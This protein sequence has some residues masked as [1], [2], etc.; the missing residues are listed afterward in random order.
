MADQTAA[1]T[2]VREKIRRVGK[3]F[4]IPGEM[5]SLK[6]IKNGLINRTY[7]ADYADPEEEEPVPYL[8][9]CVNTYVFKDPEE[10]MKNIEKV[11]EHLE[12]ANTGQKVLRF[13]YSGEGE[14]RRNYSSGE[15]GFWRVCKFIPSVSFNQAED[16][17]M[18][19][20]EGRAFGDFQRALADFDPREL[21][22][23]IPQFHDTRKRFRD[24]RDA[25][26]KDAAGRKKEVT[27]ELSW[28]LGIEDQACLLTDLL[29]EGKL[30]LRV[31]HNDTKLN[32]VLFDEKTL[33]P[34]AII[35]LDTVMPGVTGSDFG[36]A[37]RTGANYTEEDST[38]LER[39]GIDL[40]NFRAFTD[41]FLEKTAKALTETEIRTL[42]DAVLAMTVENGI[43]FLEDYLRGDVYFM[44]RD[45]SHNL[46]R[47]RCQ[48]A[49][50]KDILRHLPEMREIVAGYAEKYGA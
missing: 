18:L 35:D 2:E 26:E 22:E 14:G 3:A 50:A 19:R 47:T 20:L 17:S 9:Q 43:R 31:T 48:I 10:L 29:H 16:S 33:A 36:E 6:E 15:D 28:L 45:A 38:D 4:R 41:G 40:E 12:A 7:R 27:E 8:F 21:Y 37:I 39:T 23:T 1:D 13:L 30:P 24:L 49:L 25:A 46:D 34:L 44:I 42:P 11:T 32:N 5:V